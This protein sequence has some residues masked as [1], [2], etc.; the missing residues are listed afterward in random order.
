MVFNHMVFDPN[1]FNFLHSNTFKFTTI[2]EPLQQFISSFEFF[3][4][5]PAGKYLQDVPGPSPMHTFLANTS[6]YEM[7]GYLSLTNN[8]QSV[9]LGYDLNYSLSDTLYIQQF[10]AMVEKHFDLVLISDFFDESLVYL[11]RLLGWSTQDIIYFKKWSSSKKNKPEIDS[12]L[13][14][15]HYRHSVADR[16]LYDHFLEIFKRKIS[17]QSGLSEEVREFRDVLRRV[18]EFCDSNDTGVKQLTISSGAWTDGVSILR[19]K[20]RWLRMPEIQFTGELKKQQ[21]ALLA[22]S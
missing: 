16:A 17:K 1:I 10:I 22:S 9:D 18:G 11:K 3:R 19:S 21:T 2:R 7:P 12:R 13:R 20:C 4:K 14:A 6:R 5:W 8:R 15:D